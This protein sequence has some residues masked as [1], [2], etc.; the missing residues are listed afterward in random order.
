MM[1]TFRLLIILLVLLFTACTQLD[2]NSPITSPEGSPELIVDSP[3]LIADS[4][5]P[6]NN[7]EPTSNSEQIANSESGIKNP[8]LLIYSPDAPDSKNQKILSHIQPNNQVSKSLDRIP[9]NL[10]DSPDNL[11]S[12]NAEPLARDTAE[13]TEKAELPEP[14]LWKRIVSGFRF[15]HKLSNQ[16]IRR[17]IRDYS[18]HPADLYRTFKRSEPFLYFIVEEAEK[19][20]IPLELALLPVVESAFNP[21]AYSTH[22]AAGIWQFIPNT[23]RYYGLKQTWWY[24]GRRDVIA[25]TRAAFNYLNYLYGRFDQD[26]LL[27]LAAYNAG[28]GTVS[29]TIRRNKRAGKPTDYWNLRLPRETK[30]YVPRLLA[31][32]KIV[33]DPKKYGVTLHPMANAPLFDVVEIGSQI[34]LKLAATLAG[35][36]V[37]DLYLFNPG[38]KQ[39]ATDPMGPHRLAIPISKMEN[40]TRSLANIPKDE[41]VT[42]QR[43]IIKK[44]DSLSVIAQ[45][46]NT[47][48]SVLQDFNR[49]KGS[50]I[51]AGKA[52]LIPNS[53]LLSRENAQGTLALN[54]ASKKSNNN[55]SRRLTYKVRKG[56]TLWDISRDYHVNIRKLASWNNMAPSDIL[57]PGRKLTIWQPRR[58]R[59]LS[60]PTQ[61]SKNEHLRRI[62]Y[63]V[64]KGDSLYRIANRYNVSINDLVIWNSLSK[65]AYL[66]PGQQINIYV[67]MAQFP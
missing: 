41:R 25:S 37:D 10:T 15:S 5:E 3:E 66:K 7:S 40:F 28:S 21:F 23:G 6:T 20:R 65:R 59:Q 57:R 22:R 54:Q 43:Y 27:A 61:Y 14:D 32:A 51:R 31:I 34:D 17:E 53:K 47:T 33:A 19:R 35:M 24:D 2:T 12:T 26:W 39:W 64:R 1:L 29:K 60:L 62:D 18:N 67:N 30:A 50:R 52:L 45:K 44:G 8:E 63:R 46:H 38:F 58:S 56:D 11:E 42:W 55:A 13:Q 4:P 36:E 16:R 49:I 9:A 48:V